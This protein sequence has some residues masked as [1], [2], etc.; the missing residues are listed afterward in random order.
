MIDAG[1]GSLG[2][3]GP[4]MCDTGEMDHSLAVANER[5]PVQ[6]SQQVRQFDG[7]DSRGKPEHVRSTGCC[8][9]DMTFGC[10]LSHEGAADKTRSTGHQ[11]FHHFAR[12][13][14]VSN[15][16]TSVAPSR[17]VMISTRGSAAA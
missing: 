8:A 1:M 11:N 13:N 10:K 6:R 4:V 17:R 15:S 5:R 14:V 9:Y 16:A 7:R 3:T 2:D 12:L